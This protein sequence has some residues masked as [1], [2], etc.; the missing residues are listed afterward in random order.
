MEKAEEVDIMPLGPQLAP[1]VPATRP[2]PDLIMEGT[3]SSIN[4]SSERPCM[5]WTDKFR[6][7]ACKGTIKVDTFKKIKYIFLRIL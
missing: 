4:T 6:Y 5:M 1:T 2:C 7:W 3:G